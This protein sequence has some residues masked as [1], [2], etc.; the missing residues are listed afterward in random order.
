MKKEIFPLFIKFKQ[1]LKY[2]NM[3]L[4]VTLASFKGCDF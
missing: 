1:A 3:A 4:Y 2:V